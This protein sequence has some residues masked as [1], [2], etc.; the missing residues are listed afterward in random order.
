MVKKGWLFKDQLK[1]GSVIVA[2]E[3]RIDTEDE[4]DPNYE[5]YPEQIRLVNKSS[6]SSTITEFRLLIQK[7]K[8]PC[9]KK[10]EVLKQKLKDLQE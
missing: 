7:L 10:K 9:S 6:G 1:G 8:K 4:I 3:R 2:V 5:V